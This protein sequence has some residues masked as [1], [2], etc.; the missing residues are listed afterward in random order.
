MAD[1]AEALDAALRG[2]F[3]VAEVRTPVSQRRGLLARMNQLEKLHARP[4]D[5]PTQTRK[6]AAAASGIPDRTWRDWRNGTHP[7]SAASQRKLEGA[8]TR[9][10][11]LPA[12]RKSARQKG[13]PDKVTVTAEVWWTDSDKKN[14]G[15]QRTV[16]LVGLKSIMAGVIRT[17][18]AAGPAPAAAAFE[19]GCAR[20]YRVP[21][22]DDEE[23][24]PGIQFQGDDV[25]IEFPKG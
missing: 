18:I 13:A 1:L 8:Y 6:R 3:R 17:W 10:I 21:D 16:K 2:R 20:V 9:Q 22:N 12:Y 11:T 19:R 14:N 5:T 15:K 24:S 4:G 23:R 7:P 25:T